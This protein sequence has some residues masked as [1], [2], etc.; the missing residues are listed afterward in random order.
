MK[1]RTASASVAKCGRPSSS[2]ARFETSSSPSQTAKTGLLPKPFCRSRFTVPATASADCE[3]EASAVGTFST[4]TA[5]FSL[6]ARRMSRAAPYR[7]ASASPMMSIG[8]ARDQ[9]GGSARSSAASASG[10]TAARVPPRSISRSTASTPTP[11]PLV[12]IARRLPGK[13]FCRPRVSAA[14]KSSSRSNTRR[15]PARRKAA[16]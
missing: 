5:S 14:A 4:R 6:S 3:A 10:E 16:S 11:P 2:K 9:I 8:F 15:S 1:P 7:A 13:G 12:R